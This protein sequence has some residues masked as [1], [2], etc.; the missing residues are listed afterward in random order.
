MA[1][2]KEKESKFDYNNIQE[3]SKQSIHFSLESEG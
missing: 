2:T 1:K 3:L